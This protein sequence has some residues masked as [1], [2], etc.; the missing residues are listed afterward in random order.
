[1]LHDEV[2][3]EGGERGVK[4]WKGV[5]LVTCGEGSLVAQTERDKLPQW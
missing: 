3:S 1:M 4:G 2:G 5:G